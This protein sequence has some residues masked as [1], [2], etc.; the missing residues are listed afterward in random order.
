MSKK[1]DP[2]W[3]YSQGSRT[4]SGNR[5]IEEV[6]EILKKLELSEY[7]EVFE[8]EKMD[9]QAL[10]RT[11]PLLLSLVFLLCFSSQSSHPLHIFLVPSHSHMKCLREVQQEQNYKEQKYLTTHT[12]LC[13]CTNIWV[14][15][16]PVLVHREKP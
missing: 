11:S 15:Y 9:R 7:C 2:S 5:G 8:K 16:F 3:L 12:P 14:A 13:S 6:R 1:H 10:V 4:T